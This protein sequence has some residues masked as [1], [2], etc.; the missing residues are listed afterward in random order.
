MPSPGPLGWNPARRKPRAVWR[1]AFAGAEFSLP[2]GLSTV[3][4]RRPY[5]AWA[6]R[7]HGQA[8]IVLPAP[9]GTADPI[10]S[11]GVRPVAIR[12]PFRRGR[13][14]FGTL[15]APPPVANPNGPPQ[16][17]AVQ[18]GQPRRRGHVWLPIPARTATADPVHPGIERPV[19][20]RIPFRRGRAWLPFPA[21]LYTPDPIHPGIIR[22]V[23][24]RIPF[25]RGRVWLEQIV[26]PFALFFPGWHAAGRNEGRIRQ[27]WGRVDYAPVISNVVPPA[28]QLERF[29]PDAATLLGVAV[30]DQTLCL[31]DPDWAILLWESAPLA[32]PYPLTVGTAIDL[33]IQCRLIGGIIPGIMG[34][35]DSVTINVVPS[36][37]TVALFSPTFSWYTAGGSQT[38]YDQAQV[39]A[40]ISNAQ[41]SLLMPSALYDIAV[42]WTPAGSP[43]RAQLVARVPIV[44]K[45]VAP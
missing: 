10:H 32:V 35:S 25:R 39:L 6:A 4:A 3:I 5:R 41:A 26:P 1:E 7:F 45:A 19:A 15:D 44:G 23:A 24:N 8:R 43:G 42:W 9:L 22:P 27:R 12:T 36:R 16:P 20:I 21:P 11:A 29:E 40:S 31:F 28:P 2:G 38:G 30:A 37:Q 13:V 33:P 34:A 14:W 18:G 17:H